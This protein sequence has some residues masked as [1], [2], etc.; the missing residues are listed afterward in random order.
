MH[1]S[2]QQQV[3]CA[4]TEYF[5]LVEAGALA[6]DE[7]VELLDGLIVSMS[8]Q[9]PLHAATVWWIR[10]RL[11][12]LVG[13]HAIVRSQLPLL[14]AAASVP[15]PDVAVVPFRSDGYQSGHP[16]RC[17]LVVEAADSS[18]GQ[19]RLTKSRIYAAAEIPDYWLVNLR[20]QR[21]EWFRAPDARAY[22]YRESG[23]ATAD[24]GLPPTPLD[25]RLCAEDLFP[26]R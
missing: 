14:A 23:I 13:D 11:A 15:E 25:L 3:R 19:D 18:V 8:P 4:A 10:G 17:L 1:E 24:E 20:D 16:D 2:D 7:R 12:A 5:A 22:R 9:Q 26:P 6:P 21:V